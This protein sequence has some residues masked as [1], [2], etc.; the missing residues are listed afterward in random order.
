LKLSQ[1]QEFVFYRT[2]SR[3][4]DNLERRETWN[5]AVDRYFDFFEG[6]FKA[7]VPAKVWKKAKQNVMEMG[8]MPS[9]RAFWTAGESLDRDN[10][11][12]YN[13][14]FLAFKDLHSPKE[15]FHILMCGTGVGFSV[16]KQFID[17]MPAVKP[18]TGGGRGVM[19][20]ADSKEGWADALYAGL[21]AWFNGFDIEF[22]YSL[23]RPRG[24]RLK[25]MGGRASGPEPLKE[26]L[27][28]VRQII[29]NATEGRK[30]TS[31]EWLD[32]G[33]KIAEVVVVGGVRRS[34]EITFSDLDDVAMRS[35]KDFSQGAVPLHRYMSNNSAVYNGRPDLATFLTEWV[36]LAKSGSGERGI[37][38]AATA[39][40]YAPRRSPALLRSNPCG[41]ILL[42]D[43]QF[44]NLSEVVV[45]KNDTF[46]TLSD[47]VKSAVWLGAMQSCLT[48][49]PY[50]RA[51]FA[52]N[53]EEERL[54]G[55]SLTGQ[56]DN[57]K[58][59]TAE[60]L[61]DLRDVAIAEARKACK[62][63]EIN[64]SVA[65]TTGK[66]SGTV[67]Q[68]VDA[69]SGCHPRFAK[70]YIRR[71]RISSSD[72]LC[73]LLRSQ[74]VPMDPEV[75]Q[76][77]ERVNKRR[78][79]LLALGRDA[80]EAKILVP[81]WDGESLVDTWVIPFPEKAP[82]GATLRDDMTALDQLE[83]YKKVRTSW[84]EH[85]QSLTVYV[86]DNEWL[87]VAVW[88]W[89]NFD[90]VCG[91]SFLPYD[92]GHYKLAPYEEISAATYSELKDKFPTIDYSRLSEFEKED[93]TTGAQSL[94]CT[95]A[96]CEIP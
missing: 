48:N 76:G 87:D 94:A 65:I 84:C 11:A 75:G 64:M 29:L 91:V 72:P 13:C 37:F 80:D 38:N 77:P 8:T 51:D 18:Q 35:A 21:D 4:Q 40:D 42:R 19:V 49:F 55:V 28:F 74:N 81:D 23:I 2:Y 20:V 93:N 33:N 95:A 32:I 52:K 5:E 30:L 15:L 27:T 50:L 89:N 45:R 85:N 6:K 25:T 1:L 7:K 79:E 26:L 63:L 22:D 17:Q 67:S 54:L 16:E 73:K 68:L 44:C 78:Q 71:V 41:E 57:P 58:L 61:E 66:P 86:R 62:A 3:W 60:R 83:W 46:A 10:T 47:K 70:H 53:C 12:G 90:L 14:C 56:M 31:V 59:L 88:V 39:L 82:T 69:A 34:S 96:G 92:G 36:A 24:S 9:M 43:S